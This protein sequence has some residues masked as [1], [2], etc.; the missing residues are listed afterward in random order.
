MRWQANM[1]GGTA[2]CG[3]LMKSRGSDSKAVHSITGQTGLTIGRRP[4][5]LTP[6]PLRK[7]AGVFMTRWLPLLD[8]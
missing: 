3:G 7:A 6:F 1:V 5:F 4:Q 8:E 2:S